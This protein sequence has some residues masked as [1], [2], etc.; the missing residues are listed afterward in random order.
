MKRLLVGAAGVALAGAAFLAPNALAHEPSTLCGGAPVAQDGDSV[1][2]CTPIG[3]AEA[4]GS[5]ST[6]SGYVYAD[7]NSSNPGPALDGYIGAEGGPG[8]VTAYGD[9][10]GDWH[11][12]KTPI[13]APTVP[14]AGPDCT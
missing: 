9:C 13:A 1:T 10:T 7:G 3:A 14:P 6:T 12:G 5:A 2:A 4:G 11:D 8:G